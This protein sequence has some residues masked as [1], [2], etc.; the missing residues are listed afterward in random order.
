MNEN[1]V[2]EMEHISKSFPGVHAL[3]DV[4]FVAYAG[5]VNVLIGENGAGKSTLMKVLAGVIPCDEGFIRLKGEQVTIQHPLDASHHGIAMIH[6]ELNL[7]PYMTI[8][9]NIF[10][11]REPTTLGV[12]NRAEMRERARQL[13]R[14]IGLDIEPNTVVERLG[15]GQQQM[16]EIMKALSLGATVIVMDE[17]TS[18]LTDHEARLLFRLIERLKEDNVAV[19]YISHRLAEV[20]EIGDYITILRDGGRVGFFRAE[21]VDYATVIRHMVGR[22]INTLFPRSKVQ[23]GEIVL[24]VRSLTKK[25]QF[26]DISFELHRGEILGFFGL[27]GAGRSEI[28]HAIFGSDPADSGTILVRGREVNVKHPGHAL[29]A[30]MGLVPEDR[31]IQGLNMMSSVSHNISITILESLS[32][33][34]VISS[35]KEGVVCQSLIEKLRIV[36]PHRMQLVNNLS[37]GNQQKIV[38]SKWIAR[39]ALIL[40]L[41]EPTRGVDVGAKAEIHRLMDDLSQQGVAIIMI[42]SELPEILGMSDRICVIGEG[43]LKA[44]LPK[45][46]ADQETIMYYATGTHAHAN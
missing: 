29:A 14:S 35:K 43:E 5:R 24:E 7:L 25:N 22:E 21:E 4:S 30:G 27:V 9:E 39:N 32:R 19:I 28:V 11:G 42:S 34:G 18:S 45:D 20:F 40:I 2:L 33:Y 26:R 10:L 8:A 15:T 36:T 37:G 3:K 13:I 44:T 38:L 1:A 6:Q 31:K 41:D 23:P 16:V 17:P 46:A 12:V